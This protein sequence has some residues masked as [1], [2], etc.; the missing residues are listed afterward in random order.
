MT[1]GLAA[2]F[3]LEWNGVSMLARCAAS[4][5]AYWRSRSASEASTNISGWLTIASLLPAAPVHPSRI[6]VQLATGRDKAALGYDY[7][8]IS[9]E[10]ET[11]F[12]NKR[13]F[14]SNWGQTNRLLTGPF[15]S[16]A[17]A[18]AFLGQLRRANVSGAFVWTSP[19]G[20]VVDAL[21][22]R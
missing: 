17:A 10:A 15:D 13:A 21:A 4:V 20:Q 16:E 19:T 8:R 14:V 18:N 5:G 9:R 22:A 11:A 1:S 12:K 2:P 6:W 7:R 3:Q